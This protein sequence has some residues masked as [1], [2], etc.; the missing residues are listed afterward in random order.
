M[1]S[2]GIKMEGVARMIDSF[3]VMSL[4]IYLETPDFER[5]KDLLELM[6]MSDFGSVGPN[7]AHYFFL[8][9]EN[10]NFVYVDVAGQY[11]KLGF[12]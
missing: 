6:R 2:T 12:L 11:P 9:E 8:N 7:V 1:L 3:Q 10:S 5:H 4:A